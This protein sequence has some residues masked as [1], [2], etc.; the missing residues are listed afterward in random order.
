MSSERIS[1][2][3]PRWE[4][5]LLNV[6]DLSV[7]YGRVEALRGVSLSVERGELVAVVGP[8]GAGKSTLLNTVAGRIRAERGEI[9]FAARS[10][11]RVAPE[12]IV[13]LGLG[14]V[15]E[16][17]HIFETLSVG[18]NLR[19]GRMAS[20]G[21]TSYDDV[22]ELVARRFPVLER[23]I[24]SPAGR[25]SGGEQQQLAIARAMATKPDM[26]LLDEPSLGLAPLMVDQVFELI[27]Q[28]HQ[29]GTPILLVEQNAQ[30]AVR[31]ADR[32]Y[33]LR[34]GR[35]VLE[36]RREELLTTFDKMTSAY[37]GG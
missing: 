6:E 23:Y 32:S 1:G 35:I 28:L 18:E 4:R 5:T 30:R 8:N 10:L 15:P 37:L 20:R 33:V 17:R 7:R 26:L 2:K 12:Q 16:G 19:L 24:D 3:P 14:L 27:E 25:L 22:R 36:G 29:E 11:T 34:S 9:S 31:L 21:R 13:G